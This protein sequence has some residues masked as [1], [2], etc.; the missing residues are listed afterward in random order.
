MVTSLPAT[1]A[2]RLRCTP[3]GGIFPLQRARRS[4]QQAQQAGPA[5]ATP[6]KPVSR[7]GCSPA[8]IMP[9]AQRRARAVLLVAGGGVQRACAVCASRAAVR[10]VLVATESPMK[11]PGAV[12]T[13]PRRRGRRSPTGARY[14]R[15][16][17]G[18]QRRRISGASIRSLSSRGAVFR[19]RAVQYGDFEVCFSS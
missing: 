8:S 12:V 14:R 7:A 19:G 11:R 4:I 15:R 3:L 6:T 5:T 16:S 1:R 2:R 18:R 13:R 9:P 10:T 17:E